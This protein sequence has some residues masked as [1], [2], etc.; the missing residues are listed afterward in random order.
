MHAEFINGYRETA[1]GMRSMRAKRMMKSSPIGHPEALC[2]A[3]CLSLNHGLILQ[4]A[5]KACVRSEPSLLLHI[6][7]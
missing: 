2:I 5:G 3:I 6:L 1:G 4:H 7:E